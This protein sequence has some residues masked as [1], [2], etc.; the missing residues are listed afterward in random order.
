MAPVVVPIPQDQEQQ[1]AQQEQP[2]Q[3]EVVPIQQDQEQE[4]P[5]QL[6][7][8][9][10]FCFA[11]FVTSRGPSRHKSQHQKHSYFFTYL[12]LY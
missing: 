8:K 1:P 2:P 5:A 9:V 11:V 6:K 7:P 10:Q 3:P 12:V 4:Q